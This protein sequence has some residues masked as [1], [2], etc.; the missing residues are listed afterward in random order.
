MGSDWKAAAEA[1]RNAI[2]NSIPAKWRLDS[3]PSV[4]EQ[5]DVT[6]AYVQKYLSKEEIEITETDAVGIAERVASGAWSAV[7][8]TEAFCHR[9]SIA[10]Q[11][12]SDITSAMICAHR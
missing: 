8:V 3:I 1:K 10:H 5:K 2:L 12:V 4:E 6:G 9:A 7:S 11:I